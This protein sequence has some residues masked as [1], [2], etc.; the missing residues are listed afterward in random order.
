MRISSIERG[1]AAGKR[2]IGFRLASAAGGITLLAA[3]MS[4]YTCYT[5]KKEFGRGGYPERR[6][7]Y[8]KRYYPDFCGTHSRIGVSFMSGKNTLRGFIYGSDIQS[9]KGLIVFAHGITVGHESYINQL[10]WFV[11]RGW[12]VFTYDAT[13]SGTS[14]GSGTVG[15]VQSALDLDKALTFAENDEL[16]KDLPVYL[17]GHSWGGYAVCAVL[18]FGHK[19]QAVASMSGY[20]YPMKMYE[21]GTERAVHG[22]K[23]AAKLFMP[24]V[25]AYNRAVAKK[26]AKLN[27]VDGINRSGELPVLIIHGKH[28]NYVD[29]DRVSIYSYRDSITDPNAE[30]LVLHGRYADHQ[31]FFKTDAANDL[32]KVFYEKRGELEKKYGGLG[33]IPGEELDAFFAG[34]DMDS[35]N[36]P[37]SGLLEYIEAFYL[38]AK[39]AHGGEPSANE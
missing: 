35:L 5:M 28:D 30:Y 15:L 26:S 18:N 23:A 13:G 31:C 20:A 32:T 3:A 25:S 12:R 17:L 9:P 39:T 6:F 11:D 34:F 7:S 36:E 33:N 27:A 19:V 4:A 1:S 16:L 8:Q 22:N 24:Y 29:F 10:M 38:K 2:R 14:E 37:N 21:L